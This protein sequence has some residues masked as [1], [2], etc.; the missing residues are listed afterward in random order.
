M[1]LS[2][3]NSPGTTLFQRRS[4]LLTFSSTFMLHIAL[5]DASL[6]TPHAKRNFPRELDARLSI[7]DV[8]E[9]ELPPPVTTTARTPSLR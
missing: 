6:G 1:L 3:K 5:L 7:F 2:V 8:N 4:I 9:G